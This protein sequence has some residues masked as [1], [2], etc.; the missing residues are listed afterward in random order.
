MNG[1]K[2]VNNVFQKK[3]QITQNFKN[4]QLID[5]GLNLSD[6]KFRQEPQEKYEKKKTSLLKVPRL[7]S[8]SDE[9]PHKLFCRV[10]PQGTVPG[11]LLFS[12][13]INDITSDIES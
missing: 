6:Y 3:K 1:R 4:Q 11:P 12:L 10:S 8:R 5:V 13:Y 7:P 9:R 2:N